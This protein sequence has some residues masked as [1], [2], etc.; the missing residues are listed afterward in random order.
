MIMDVINLL[1]QG[2]EVSDLAM[3]EA[4]KVCIIKAIDKDDNNLTAVEIIECEYLSYQ[5]LGSVQDI[6]TIRLTNP[7][8][9]ILEGINCSDELKESVRTAV[10]NGF[11]PYASKKNKVFVP[12]L[13]NNSNYKW[14]HWIEKLKTKMAV[15][16]FE[17]LENLGYDVT[18]YYLHNS[19]DS[20]K[21]KTDYFRWL[22]LQ[23]K[24][25]LIVSEYIKLQ[26]ITEFTPA[27]LKADIQLKYPLLNT[28]IFKHA[29][30]EEI[31]KRMLQLIYNLTDFKLL[32]F[33]IFV[34]NEDTN[35]AS[36]MQQESL[37]RLNK[38]KD[39]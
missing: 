13:V 17:D 34:A 16:R 9:D 20:D 28:S 22:E 7:L 27:N 25:P 4:V 21:Q 5:V 14:I 30:Y 38:I 33:T 19:S 24:I 15:E 11:R 10:Y 31:S 23:E 8:S 32:M 29:T 26:S 39:S 3:A 37:I 2:K 6:F 12:S 35:R 18:A 1:K 36:V